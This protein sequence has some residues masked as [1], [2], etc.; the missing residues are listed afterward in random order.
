MRD[1]TI[2]FKPLARTSIC[3]G[4]AL[5]LWSIGSLFFDSFVLPSPWDTFKNFHRLC[6]PLFFEH[7]ALTL[8]RVVVGFSVSFAGGTALGIIAHIL[9][10]TPL[11]ES[12]MMMV[13]VLPG[14]IVGV[15][16]LLMAG[17]G[18]VAPVLLI[19]TMT[20]PLIAMNTAAGL[21]KTD[22]IM[23][24]VILSFFGTRWDYIRDLYLPML[25]PAMGANASMGAT[26]AMKIALLGEFIASEN[27][28]GYLVNVSRIY[29]NMEEVFFYIAV[30]LLIVMGFQLLISAVFFLFL[31]K[32]FYPA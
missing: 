8:V 30:I 28:L 1:L 11:V 16:F 17:V 3:L 9:K 31:K 6:T 14:F 29:F 15:I 24:K 13:Q 19:I 22:P 7:L 20:T 23:E 10:I 21:A 26:M 27:G 5:A 2:F 32:Y 12:L 25:V 18:S 4:I